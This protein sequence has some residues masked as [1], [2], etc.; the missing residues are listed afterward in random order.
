M[1]SKKASEWIEHRAQYL[2]L[3]VDNLKAKGSAIPCDTD[4]VLDHQSNGYYL[5]SW[6]KQSVFWLKEVKAD[7]VTKE[8]RIPVSRSHISEYLKRSFYVSIA[9]NTSRVPDSS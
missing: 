5:V 4:L 1:S 9:H 7:L 6:K 2:L 3:Q 8:E